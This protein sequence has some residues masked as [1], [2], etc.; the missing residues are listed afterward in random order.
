MRE[1]KNFTR[2]WTRMNLL[3]GAHQWPQQC[4]YRHVLLFACVCVRENMYAVPVHRHTQRASGTQKCRMAWC[5]F[6]RDSSKNT[7]TNPYKCIESEMFSALL[8]YSLYRVYSLRVSHCSVSLFTAL[9]FMVCVDTK[10]TYTKRIVFYVLCATLKW[11]W[12]QRALLWVRCFVF[13]F[14]SSFLVCMCLYKVYRRRVRLSLS[15]WHDCDTH[16]FTYICIL[17][18]AFVSLALYRCERVCAC[19]KWRDAQCCDYINTQFRMRNE[20]V[21][22]AVKRTNECA[23]ECVSACTAVWKNAFEVQLCTWCT[24][25]ASV[26]WTT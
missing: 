11:N 12:C 24:C 1:R 16:I 2:R 5:S 17:R 7:H 4:M 26:I 9:L 14:C 18:C 6:S 15:T 20:F 25:I 3:S 23:I 22:R 13:F 8:F 10:H 19:V 21:N